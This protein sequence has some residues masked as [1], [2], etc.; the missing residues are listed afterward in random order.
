MSASVEFWVGD[1]NNINNVAGSG[2]GFYGTGGFGY[3]IAIGSYNG[4]TFIT[5]STGTDQGPECNNNQYVNTSGVLVGQEGAG[6]P[7]VNLPNYLSTLNIRFTNDTAVKLQTVKLYACDGVSKNNNPS[8]VTVYAAEII[9]PNVVQNATGSGDSTWANIYGSGSI[10]SLCDGPGLSGLS[11]NGPDTESTQHDHFV[12]IAVT[13]TSVGA[14]TAQ[15]V[16]ECEYL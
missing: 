8:G 16:Y 11:P 5:D 4:R 15:L 10:L 3:S 2:L 6:I 13:P 9:H 1:G 7:L 14:K 12:A